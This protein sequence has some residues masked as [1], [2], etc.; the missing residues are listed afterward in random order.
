MSSPTAL[1][2]SSK[3]NPEDF[4]AILAF[5]PLDKFLRPKERTDLDTCKQKAEAVGLRTHNCNHLGHGFTN[6]VEGVRFRGI[7]IG[8]VTLVEPVSF[9]VVEQVDATIKN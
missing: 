2:I 8:T 9:A 3:R 4:L 6:S 1:S 5:D 7:D